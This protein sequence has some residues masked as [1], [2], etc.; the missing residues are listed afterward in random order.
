MATT[1]LP[2]EGLVMAHVIVDAPL[3]QQFG[4]VST[5]KHFALSEDVDDVGILYSGETVGHSNSSPSL[6]HPFKGRLHELLAFG[7]KRASRFIKQQHTRITDKSPGNRQP[8]LL[9]AT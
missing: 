1:D 8:L 4:M 7:V 5:L 9:S 2:V 6:G 3:P